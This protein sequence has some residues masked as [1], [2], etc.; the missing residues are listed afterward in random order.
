MITSF[1]EF[2]NE[3]MSFTEIKDKYE[4]NPYGIGANSVEF[5]EG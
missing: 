1:N 2:I 3:K 5:V 4:N